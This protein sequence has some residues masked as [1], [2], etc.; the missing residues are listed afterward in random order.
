M[1]RSTRLDDLTTA[2]LVLGSGMLGRGQARNRATQASS[3]RVCVSIEQCAHIS[4]SFGG[5]RP[6]P[7][8]PGLRLGGAPDRR[9]TYSGRQSDSAWWSTGSTWTMAMVSDSPP[10]PAQ[11]TRRLP[12]IQPPLRQARPAAVVFG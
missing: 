5:R 1:V 4:I 7:P 12:R 9:A 8:R 3:P 6:A 11:R 10:A 2:G